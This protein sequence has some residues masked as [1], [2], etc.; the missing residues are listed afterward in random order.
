MLSPKTEN[1]IRKIYMQKSLYDLLSAMYEKAKKKVGF[2][3]AYYVLG[4]VRPL[5]YTT[6]YYRF[7][8][9]VKSSGVKYITLHGLRHSHASLLIDSGANDTLVAERLGHTVE[10]LHHVYAHIYRH[11]QNEFEEMLDKIL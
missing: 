8:K 11:K 3:Q 9:D 10:M 5:K 2:N 6:M 7:Q 4:D 1:S